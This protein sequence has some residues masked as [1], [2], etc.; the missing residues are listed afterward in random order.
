MNTTTLTA[1]KAVFF[2]TP[3]APE[4]AVAQ[5]G[6]YCPLD[7]SSEDESLAIDRACVRLTARTCYRLYVNG[8]MVMHGPARTAHGYCRVDEV[9]ITDRLIDGVNHIAVEVVTFNNRW[10]GYNRYSNDYTMEDGLFI[11]E[12]EADGKI[13]TATGRDDWRV[14]EIAARSPVSERIS[15]SRECTENY[16]LDDNYYLWKLGY[17][18]FVPAAVLADEPIYLTHEALM[19]TLTEY[20]FK[21][22]MGF[23]ACAIDPDKA[24]SPLFYE[25]NSPF[26]DNLPE[27]PTADC[28]RT[29]ETLTGEVRAEWCDEGLQLSPVDT[30]D[31]FAM[32]D[33]GESRVGFLRIAVTCERAG[34]I[35]L[36]HTELLNPD[37]TVPYYHNI[38]TRLHVPAGFTE[39][40]TM[41]PALARYMLVYFRG[42]GDVTVHTLSILDDAYPDEHRATFLC[43]DDNVNRLYNAAKKTLLLN[44]LDIFMD[45]PERERGGWLCDSLWTGR[46]ASLM[47]G[48]HRVEREFIEN[49]LLTPAD[50]MFHSFFPEV[51]PALKPSYKDMTGITT[52]SFWLMCEVCEFIRRTGDTAFRD[53]H[54][55]R[56]EAFVQG[57]RDFM[58]KS[59][60]LERLPWLFID[61]SMS[62]LGEYQQPVSSAANALYAYMMVE[63]GE[64]FGESD[65][66]AEGQRVK[67]VLRNAVLN[68]QRAEDLRYIPDSFDVDEQGGLHSRGYHSE[69][70]MYTA[71]WCGLFSPEEAPLLCKTV[72]DKMGPA[73]IFAKDP[74]VGGSQLFIGL[75]IRLD[76]LARLGYHN[77]S[78]EDML[79]IYEPQLK[80]G[81]GTLWENEAIDTSSRCHGFSSHA[82]VQLMRDVLGLGFHIHGIDGEGE[83][84][85]EIA[86]HI[87]GLR[88]ARGTRET[89]EGVVSV[90]WKYDGERFV[91][92]VN[93]P[94]AYTC[95]VV[96]PK[97]VKMLDE[98]KASVMV[99]QY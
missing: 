74:M 59:G 77:K 43:S 41:E 33:G 79:A 62:N 51:Y 73:P 8:E 95:R 46:A 27:H 30:E 78:F 61:W 58:G 96:L 31:H 90:D 23:G 48:D 60:L 80:E 11:A 7:L 75:C 37:G 24:I 88:W 44:T 49:F 36:V 67:A 39:V 45:C 32:W 13:L 68:G 10:G 16:T 83:P 3:I 72:R 6:F 18:E 21:D 35:D 20:A 28:R 42:V 71:L 29:V 81:P 14:C 53:E 92:K 26:Y 87:C 65:W 70:A 69:A 54:K 91:L 15:H 5:Y 55:P 64:T 82:G 57:T 9:D 52:W 86:P 25:V 76:M 84:V 94:A 40:V 89:P 50:G 17:G 66:V 34:V 38:V 63:L 99:K 97:E 19:P 2:P 1:A 98:G 12:V 22:L 56:I 85:L 93:A 4:A 47:L